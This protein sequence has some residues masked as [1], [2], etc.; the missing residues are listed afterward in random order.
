[1]N[2]KV[3]ILRPILNTNRRTMIEID[4]KSL[5]EAKGIDVPLF[6]GDIVYIPR[7]YTRQF[8]TTFSS[9]ALPLLPYILF[10]VAQ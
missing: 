2:D 3:R 10:L 7:S 4:A 5:F 1:V 6:P 8:W 9:V